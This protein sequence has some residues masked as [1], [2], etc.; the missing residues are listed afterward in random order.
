MPLNIRDP[1]AAELA[2]E[3]AGRRGTTMTEAIVFALKS[4][5]AREEA[6]PSL[7][8]RLKSI[9]DGLLAQAKGPRR[10]M[11]KSEIDAMWG[12]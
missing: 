6:L 7:P 12:E 5:I 3:L 10:K 1:R 4:E 11:T 9:S 2:R 8:D